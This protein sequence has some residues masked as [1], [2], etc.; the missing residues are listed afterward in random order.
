MSNDKK[1]TKLN[2]GEVRITYLHAFQPHAM[3]EGDEPKYQCC[4]V[5]PKSNK[6]LVAKINKA[7]NAAKAEGKSSKWNGKVPTNLKL[8]LR[9]GDEDRPDDEVYEDAYFINCNTTR[10]PQVVGRDRQPIIDADEFYS[11]CYGYVSVNFYP[12]NV[13]G[14]KGIAAGLGNFLKTRDGEPLV[15]GST[16]EQDFADLD[17]EDI[18]DDDMME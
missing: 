14:N 13:S 17:I 5:I 6:A 8:P 4:L 11:G 12:F 9:D 1:P 16:A 18:D 10:K 7:I 15:G 2:I 3:E